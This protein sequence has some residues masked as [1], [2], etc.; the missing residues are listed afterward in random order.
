MFKVGDKV[1]CINKMPQQALK[2]GERYTVKN[3][4]SEYVVVMEILVSH[5]YKVSRFK[6]ATSEIIKERLG[7]K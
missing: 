4:T 6:L 1:I 2:L 7:I 3:I 5:S